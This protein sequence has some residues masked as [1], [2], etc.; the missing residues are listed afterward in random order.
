[1]SIHNSRI[2]RLEVRSGGDELLRHARAVLL[3]GEDERRDAQVVGNL[4]GRNT[5]IGVEQCVQA[6][7][8]A[9]PGRC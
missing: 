1:M 3:A 2:F 5:A 7:F 6:V 4:K 8:F 9:P